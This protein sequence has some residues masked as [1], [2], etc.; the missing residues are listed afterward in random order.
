MA[1]IFAKNDTIHLHINGTEDFYGAFHMVAG[2]GNYPDS[3]YRA[4][5]KIVYSKLNK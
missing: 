4:K 5:I 3:N 2:G 1:S